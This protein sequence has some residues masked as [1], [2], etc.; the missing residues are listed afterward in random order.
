V[1][2]YR[3]PQPVMGIALQSELRNCKFFA[4]H[5]CSF[6]WRRNVLPH[7]T[8]FPWSPKHEA[9]TLALP[10]RSVPRVSKLFAECE[11]ILAAAVVQSRTPLNQNVI[12]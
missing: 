2:P 11:V 4:S 9:L 5:L 3:P 12:I 1:G 10:Q 7:T 8:D 6:C